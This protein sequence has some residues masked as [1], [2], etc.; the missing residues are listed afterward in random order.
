MQ[1]A[2]HVAVYYRLIQNR[3]FKPS[4]IRKYNSHK[5]DRVNFQWS[6][7]QYICIDSHPH[8]YPP[9]HN[10]LDYKAVTYA[11]PVVHGIFE[12]LFLVLVFGGGAL[13]RDVLVLQ[14]VVVGLGGGASKRDVLFVLQGVVVGLGGGALKRDVLV[15]LQGVVVGLGGGALKRDVLV[16]QG[17]VVGLGG[18]ALKREDEHRV[19]VAVISENE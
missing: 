2:A 4:E 16:L 7:L 10:F 11:S 5:R 17:V 18:G 14:G 12:C 15:D 3:Q 13:K 9:A 6:A 8:K 1:I 19:T